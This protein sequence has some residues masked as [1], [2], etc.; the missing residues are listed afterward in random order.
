MKY[1]TTQK[2]IRNNYNT[3]IKVYYCDAQTLLDLENPTA[4]T[5]GVYGWNA[6]IYDLGGGVAIVTGY[7]PFGNVKPAY[8][9]VK[10]YEDRAKKIRYNY[11]LTW[12]EQK[13]QLQ[14][15]IN[16]FVKE[17]KSA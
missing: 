8:D 14:Q 9:K 4:Y 13:A 3:I 11:N 16:E 1:K 6:D 17:V 7:R 12:Q 10:E 5:C 15:L 2:A